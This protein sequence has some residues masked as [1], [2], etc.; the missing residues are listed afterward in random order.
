MAADQR[1]FE[2][3]LDPVLDRAFALAVNL[4]ANRADAED[5]VQE[6]ALRAF[7]GFASFR[8]GTNFR[9]WFFRILTNAYYSR[10]R[11]ERRRPLE[12]QLGE[13]PDAYL[14]TRA[15]RSGLHARTSDPARALMSRLGVEEIQQAIQSLPDEFRVVA[16]LY[17]LEEFR[18]PEIAE[19]LDIPVGT[20]RSRLHRGR[21]IL[22]K[23]LWA[24]AESEGIVSDL[25]Q[26]D[27]D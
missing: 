17:F 5:L 14:H 6:A 4:T 18:Y 2:S 3:L 15:V 11:S 10:R 24:I 26:E 7:R 8:P 25:V 12:V 21:K 22:Q 23:E 13:V 16:A 19:V 1:R 20:V 9:A 27:V